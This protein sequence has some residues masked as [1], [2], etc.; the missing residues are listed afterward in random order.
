M[1]TVTGNVKAKSANKFGFGIMVNDKWYNSKYEIKAEKGD[2]VEFDDGGKNY[3]K[4]LKVSGRTVSDPVSAV[5]GGGGGGK[6]SFRGPFPIP[7]ADGQRSIIRQNS[8]TN[9]VNLYGHLLA[10]KAITGKD[11]PVGAVLLMAREFE[12]YSAGDIDAEITASLDEQFEV[13]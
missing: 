2:V 10:H 13:S 4:G 7:A 8:V 6:P 1:S 9:A 12:K 5:G 11:D 3:I